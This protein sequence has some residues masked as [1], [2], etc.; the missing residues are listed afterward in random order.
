MDIEGAEVMVLRS[1]S[2]ATLRA[3]GQITVEF[4]SDPVFVST[5]VAMSRRSSALCS[6]TVPVLGLLRHVRR[7]VLFVN[8]AYPLH[9]V[10]A[11]CDVGV[12]DNPPVLAIRDPE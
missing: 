8:R 3:I 9:P 11:V 2:G 5:S 7:D 12:P 1:L 4:H 10:A 6:A